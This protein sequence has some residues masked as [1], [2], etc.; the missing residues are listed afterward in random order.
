MNLIVTSASALTVLNFVLLVLA[1]IPSLI[2]GEEVSDGV[3]LV[4]KTRSGDTLVRAARGALPEETVSPATNVDGQRM[5]NNRKSNR[6]Q[7]N[8]QQAGGHK[9]RTGHKKHAVAENVS[10]VAQHPAQPKHKQGHKNSDKQQR[11]VIK[12]QQHGHQSHPGG[13]RPGP[14]AKASETASTCRYAKSAW[15][16]CDA[17][18]NMR[19]RILSLKKGEQNCLPTRTIQK[20]CKKGCRYEKGT[21]T[22]CTAGQMTREDKLQA[23]GVGASDQNCDPVRTVNKKCKGTGSSPEGK[24]HGPNRAA[25]ERKQKDKGTP[26]RTAPQE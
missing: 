26:R 19:T 10:A 23:E 13:K 15:S 1:D 4:M 22:P 11:Q 17:K 7:D 14:K 3:R 25:K 20:K 5:R 2:N 24:H 8:L 18:S 21:W 6:S 12:Q 9:S 16:N